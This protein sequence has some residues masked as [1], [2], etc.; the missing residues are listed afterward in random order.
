MARHP[1]ARYPIGRRTG[2]AAALLP[3]LAG[4]VAAALDTARANTP[5]PCPVTGAPS[6]HPPRPG[7][8]GSTADR[9]CRAA[10]TEVRGGHV[11]T[12][13]RHGRAEDAT[14][15][16]HLGA[17]TGTDYAGIAGRLA[18]TDPGVRGGS[19]D[20]V[21]AR[22]MALGTVDGRGQWLEAGWTEDGWLNDDAQH[23]Y[24]YNTNTMR[25][26]YYNQYPIKPGDRIRLV[27]QS[28]DSTEKGT[29][30]RA[31]LW[32]DNRWNLLDQQRLPIGERTA[33]EQYVEVYLDPSRSGGYRL[34]ATGV[35]DVA[36]QPASG[37][38]FT[39]WRDPTVRTSESASYPGYCVAW[40]DRHDDWS[41]ASC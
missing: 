10:P 12:R 41:A 3:L 2:A 31:W 26:S 4:P 34:P 20:F 19:N 35:T 25:W 33:I 1:L 32:W 24:T 37:R 29:T 40:R 13:P 15:Y 39:G 9:A 7:S 8:P 6:T 30:W 18:V 16:R 23:V 11:P 36:L 5:R 38:R 17:V 28:G 27:L 21:A 14:G 22:F